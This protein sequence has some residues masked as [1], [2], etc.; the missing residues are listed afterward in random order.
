MF[1]CGEKVGEG[2]IAVGELSGLVAFGLE[3]KN[4]PLG[5]V[6]FVFHEDDE[7]QHGHI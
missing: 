4:E 2:K 5:E 7:G 1:R 3:I 6:G